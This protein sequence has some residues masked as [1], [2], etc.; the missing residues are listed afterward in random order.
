MRHIHTDYLDLDPSEGRPDPADY[1]PD[2]RH[3]FT[4][5]ATDA[6]LTRDAQGFVLSANTYV[7]PTADRPF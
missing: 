3:E 5:P 2:T 7:P 6:D 1:A 4:L